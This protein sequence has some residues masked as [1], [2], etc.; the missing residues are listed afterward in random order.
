M[1]IHQYSCMSYLGFA[2]R[3][4]ISVD[5]SSLCTRINA[6]SRYLH[7]NQSKSKGKPARA[8][9]IP[10]ANERAEK[11]KAGACRDMSQHLVTVTILRKKTPTV[12]DL[13]SERT[14]L[15]SSSVDWS[16]AIKLK[17]NQPHVINHWLFRCDGYQMESI[18]TWSV[19]S[20][21]C[22]QSWPKFSHIQERLIQQITSSARTWKSFGKVQKYS[23]WKIFLSIMSVEAPKCLPRWPHCQSQ[24][25]ERCPKENNRHEAQLQQK[26]EDTLSRKIIVT[27]PRFNGKISG[28]PRT[29][30]LPQG[31]GPTDE[32]RHVVKKWKNMAVDGL[33]SF[34][35]VTNRGQEI[36]GDA[37]SGSQV[38]F[39]LRTV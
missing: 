8:K 19:W 4:F 3:L 24:P 12:D 34:F 9:S 5:G 35:G 15:W 21:A 7:G 17:C 38:N 31:T 13:W 30:S 23:V 22:D 28:T 26:A 16:H 32:F 14:N 36:K 2:P 10:Q 27:R 39:R 29:K 11:I 37:C 25:F 1:T 18:N 6:G 33:G 20:N